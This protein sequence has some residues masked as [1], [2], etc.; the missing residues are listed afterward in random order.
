MLKLLLNLF[1]NHAHILAVFIFT[2][3]QKKRQPD[4]TLGKVQNS[5]EQ[6]SSTLALLF[7]AKPCCSPWPCQS[8]ALVAHSH[9]GM[10]CT[11]WHKAGSPKPR[12]KRT[13]WKTKCISQVLPLILLRFMR[14]SY[15]S[16]SSPFAQAA[17]H[18]SRGDGGYLRGSFFSEWCLLTLAGWPA[19]SGR[20]ELNPLSHFSYP[21]WT[22]LTGRPRKAWD[23]SRKGKQCWVSWLLSL[24][25]LE[26]LPSEEI[27]EWCRTSLKDMLSLLMLL[28][29]IS[30]G[31]RW[32]GQMLPLAGE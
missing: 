6:F 18:P 23:M 11:P 27:F 22:R 14:Y 20:G 31:P 28:I 10:G 25:H 21:A 16:A 26:T 9:L 3:I 13:E 32:F 19:F 24:L 17:A 8:T 12:I 4:V 30:S 5:F 1:P 2:A 7:P 29:I 15:G